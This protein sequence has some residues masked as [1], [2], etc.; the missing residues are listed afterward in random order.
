[1]NKLSKELLTRLEVTHIPQEATLSVPL[2][3]QANFL[4]IGCNLSCTE[5]RS[6]HVAEV[7][8][9]IS[10]LNFAK[11]LAHPTVCYINTAA[12]LSKP[13]SQGIAYS[14]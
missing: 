1:M 6:Y 12:S 8:W 5:F 14:L 13:Q 4:L 10:S 7:L 2:I 11:C 9:L 3:P